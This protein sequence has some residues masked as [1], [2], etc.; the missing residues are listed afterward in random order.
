MDVEG[1]ARIKV[2]LWDPVL[3][4]HEAQGRRMNSLSVSRC[5]PPES[6]LG[7][8]TIHGHN[9]VGANLANASINKTIQIRSGVRLFKR[10]ES[11]LQLEPEAIFMS[12]RKS[13]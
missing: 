3:C 1:S 11:C 10:A 4:L 6:G 2:L 12:L 9:H 8:R 13:D 7:R 5:R